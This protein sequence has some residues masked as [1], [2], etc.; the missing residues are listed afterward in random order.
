MREEPRKRIN[1]SVPWAGVGR[2]KLAMKEGKTSSVSPTAAV[3]IDVMNRKV[4]TGIVSA[5]RTG[6]LWSIRLG[7]GGFFI[8][9][10]ACIVI[11]LAV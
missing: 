1:I 2:K 10:H 7:Y 5:Y 8:L 9:A 3:V 4:L 11:L 6:W